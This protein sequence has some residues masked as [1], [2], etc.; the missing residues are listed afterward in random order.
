MIRSK[1]RNKYLKW[2][3]KENLSVY[4]KTKFFKKAIE[5][6]FSKTCFQ[7]NHNIQEILEYSQTVLLPS[8][9]FERT[10]LFTLVLTAR[11]NMFQSR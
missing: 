9:V 4:K 6:A 7:D 8:K 5:K 3:C 1:V 10:L 11:E 2:P